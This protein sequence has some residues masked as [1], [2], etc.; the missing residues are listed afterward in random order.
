MEGSIDENTICKAIKE[1]RLKQKRRPDKESISNFLLTRRGLAMAETLN[2]IDIMIAAGKIHNQKTSN[3][4]DSFFISEGA[5]AKDDAGKR[6]QSQ[7]QNTQFGG[8]GDIIEDPIHSILDDDMT[9]HGMAPPTAGAESHPLG[10]YPDSINLVNAVTKMVDSIN[11]LNHL[12]REERS[13]SDDLLAEN[14]SLKLQNREMET[15][16]ERILSENNG[17][18]SEGL[19]K[20]EVNNREQTAAEK[21]IEIRSE[22]ITEAER[23]HKETDES[24]LSTASL[25]NQKHNGK[26]NRNKNAAKNKQDPCQGETKKLGAGKP[27][28]AGKQ[29]KVKKVKVLIVGDSQLRRIDDSKLSNDHRDIEIACKPGMKIKQAVSKVGKSDKEIII[30]H[31]ATNDVKSSTPEQLCKDVIDTLNQIQTNNPKSRI[32]FSSVIRR[33]DDQSI[34]AKVRKLNGLLDEEL[35]INGFDIID[36]DNIQYSNLWKDGLHVNE[37]GIRKLSG[38]L[39]RYVKYC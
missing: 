5:T 27:K 34:N 6:C 26:Q 16:I 2:T 21:T 22:L 3:G 33:K 25:A 8:V 38:N 14:L 30:V 37:G 13:K 11:L 17:I 39:S 19:N 15:T 1:I 29:N 9:K 36:N 24:L 4:E 10:R 7:F 28:G 32:A 23:H 31:A 20:R 35:A 18:Q 12:L